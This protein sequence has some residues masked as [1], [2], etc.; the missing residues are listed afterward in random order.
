MRAL[1]WIAVAFPI[2]IFVVIALLVALAIDII[3]THDSP[4]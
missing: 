1:V 3:R 2:A 4:E